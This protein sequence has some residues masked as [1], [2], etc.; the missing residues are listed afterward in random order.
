MKRD[1]Y[2]SWD[3]FFMSVAMIASM[4]SKDP[5]TQVGACLVDQDN[6][7]IGVGYNGFPNGCSDDVLPWNRDGDFLNSKYAYIAHAEN[8]AIHNS[9]GNKKNS[10][11]YV[12]LFPCNKC[13]IDVIQSGIKEIIYLSDKYHDEDFT[14][15]ARK[16]L[17]LAGVTY[18]KFESDTA[19]CLSLKE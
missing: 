7:I 18:R 8:N 19:I 12:T 3:E 11:I 10:K 17:D 14:I 2:I 5:S 4:R 15:A 16:M 9:Y 1:D 6:K 13:A